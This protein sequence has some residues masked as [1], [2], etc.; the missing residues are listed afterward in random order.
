[1][2]GTFLKW[3][4]DSRV[5]RQVWFFGFFFFQIKPTTF[6][7][8]VI[9][10]VSDKGQENITSDDEY[11]NKLNKTELYFILWRMELITKNGNDIWHKLM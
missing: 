10:E 2:V 8:E 6:N 5:H 9:E 4:Q 11:I 7:S 1:M 3:I